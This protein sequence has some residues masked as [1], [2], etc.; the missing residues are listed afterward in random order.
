MINTQVK[1]ILHKLEYHLVVAEKEMVLVMSREWGDGSRRARN[2]R[3]LSAFEMTRRL[4]RQLKV[5]SQQLT[6]AV[7][8]GREASFNP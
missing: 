8:R 4:S 5:G 1:R 6:K 2:A 3:F 7:D